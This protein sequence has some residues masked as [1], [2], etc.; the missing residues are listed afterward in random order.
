MNRLIK[1]SIILLFVLTGTNSFAQWYGIKGG[2]NLSRII[3]QNDAG[4]R[5][6]LYTNK[7][8]FHVGFSMQIPV[9][10]PLSFE[11]GLMVSTKGYLANYESTYQSAPVTI[12]LKS[13]LTYLE[14][15]ALPKL[16]FGLGE[17]KI[18]GLF[19]PYLGVGLDGDNKKAM[20]I[21]SS[22]LT[23][24]TS[25]NLK[26]GSE[27]G[28]DNLRRVDLG[29]K[30]G[31]GIEFSKIQLSFAY[32]MGLRNWSL[33]SSNNTISK[34]RGLEFSMTYKISYG[35]F[36]SPDYDERIKAVKRS[37]KQT[38]L[39]KVALEDKDLRV[40][41]AA[42]NK[43]NDNSL[44][45]ISNRTKDPAIVLAAKIRL[46]ETQ[47]R[48]EFDK[49]SAPGSSLGDVIGAAAL[50]NDPSPSSY[51]VVSACH[52]YIRQGDVS[53]IPE[54][55]SLLMRFGDLSLAEDYLNCGNDE[56]H[57]AGADWGSSHGYNI[58]SGNGS[59]RVR[60]GE[61]KNR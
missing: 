8:G 4:N 32:G 37:H 54:L 53:R 43:L 55:R 33:L 34:N 10:G 36:T 9:M 60:W 30:A 45:E 47:W 46:H 6:S 28:V 13:T 41:V 21:I 3:T 17:A 11:T 1:A 42:F 20:T 19:G 15:P 58:R 29:L 40:R 22:G 51:D 12:N 44:S 59:N 61:D 14:I 7:E 56:L 49:A 39:M 25:Y 38:K 27:E 5:S 31:A 18:F 26:W 48:D 2:Y 35:S 24:N 57:S 52:K 16:S 50:V 23:T